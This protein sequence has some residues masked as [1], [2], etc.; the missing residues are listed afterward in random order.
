MNMILTSSSFLFPLITVPYVSRVLSTFGT[1]AVSFVQSVV[2]Y[3]SLV[4]LLGIPV[5]GV[6]ECAKVRDDRAKLSKIVQELMMILI[7]SSG[8][9]YLLFLVSIFLIPRLREDIPLMLIFSSVIWLSSCGVEWFYQAIEQYGYIT[10]RNIIMKLVGLVL[11]FSLVHTVSDYRIYGLIVVLASYGSNLLNIVRLRRYIT[12]CKPRELNLQR[13]LKPM[14]VFAV[15]KISSGMYTQT[16][17]VLLGFFGT[18]SMVGLY[19]LVVK[20]KN[21]CFSAVN[22]VGQVM[23]PRMSYYESKGGRRKTANLVGKNLSFLIVISLALI[24]IIVLNAKSIVLL[25]G[26]E[27]FRGSALSLILISPAIFLASVNTIFT[28]YYIATGKERS[29]AVI[30]VVGLAVMLIYGAVFIPM[31]GIRGAAISVVLCEF[32]VFVIRSVML[33]HLLIEVW[34]SLGIV[35]AVFATLAAGLVAAGG[36]FLL[37][38]LPVVIQLLVSSVA[39]LLVDGVILLV[40]RHPLCQYLLLKRK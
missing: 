36:S 15:S 28:Q 35:K 20:I 11:M 12:F 16:D 10:V 5:Y 18:T 25:L 14:L 37:A 24:S 40:T 17:I 9:V 34:S 6:R 7:I 1:G 3:F 19:Q 22:S 13:H 21:L 23:L 27:A 32:T 33:R 2:S 29:S 38:G 26:G 31:M 8:I 30:D 39:Y 4:A